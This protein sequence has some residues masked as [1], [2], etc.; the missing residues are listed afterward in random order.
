MSFYQPDKLLE[1]R[2]PHFAFRVF[3]KFTESSEAKIWICL[4]KKF[5]LK[6]VD[7]P[8]DDSLR[9]QILS[10]NRRDEATDSDNE[11]SANLERANSSSP[12][13]FSNRFSM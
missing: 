8:V 13:M 6:P 11:T 7:V 4:R 1:S 5:S 9:Q 10:K 2:C 3:I 12:L